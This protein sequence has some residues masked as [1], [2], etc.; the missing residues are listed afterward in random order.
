MSTKLEKILSIL[1][2]NHTKVFF[3]EDLRNEYQL[4]F[5]EE[6]SKNALSSILTKKIR[7]FCLRTKTQLSRGFLYTYSDRCLLERFYDEY[8]VPS[9]FPKRDE[10]LLLIKASPQKNLFEHAY[11]E[12]SSFLALLLGFGLGDGSLKKDDFVLCYYFFLKADA[13]SFSRD[14][15]I[16]FSQQSNVKFH[17]GCYRVEF[18]SRKLYEKLR[19]LGFPTGN[20]VKQEFLVPNW[21]FHGSHELKRSFLRGMFGAEGSKPFRGR[22]RIQFVLSKDEEY[23]E[24]LLFFLNQLR[25]LLLF[26]GI[27]STHIQLRK[28]PRRA[29]HGR[30]YI[31]GEENIRKFHGRIGFAYAAEKQLALE[32]LAHTFKGK[33]LS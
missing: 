24:N 13:V 14:L 27:A 31:T 26:F 22:R 15:F 33:V 18:Y 32:K 29:F 12:C 30:F 19:H 10:F 23:I 9:D 1:Q 5:K 25:S 17:G 2:E 7:H 21:V 16:F 3:P 4:L 6:L 11:D 20:R 8:L 28:Q